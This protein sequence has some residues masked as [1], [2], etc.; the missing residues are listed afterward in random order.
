MFDETNV[1]KLFKHRFHDHAIETKNKILFFDF[2]YNLFIKKSETFRKYLNNNFKKRV[3]VF[4]SSF[5]NAFIMFVKKKRKFTIVSKLL[6][7]EFYHYKKT[8]FHIV[9]RTVIRSFD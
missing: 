8:L 5:T 6:K 2:V 1:N 4:F 3:I 7:F 9:N